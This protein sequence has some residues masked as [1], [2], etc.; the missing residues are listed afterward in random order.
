MKMHDILKFT[1]KEARFLSVAIDNLTNIRELSESSRMT[2]ACWKE[3]EA[4]ILRDLQRAGFDIIL[5]KKEWHNTA[6]QGC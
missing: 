3:Y 5:P 6:V 1:K 4:Q 2:T